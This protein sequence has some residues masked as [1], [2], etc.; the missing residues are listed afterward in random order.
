MSLMISEPS[1]KDFRDVLKVSFKFLNDFI[2][3]LKD[4]IDFLNDIL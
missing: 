4:F 3:F 1:L 2:D